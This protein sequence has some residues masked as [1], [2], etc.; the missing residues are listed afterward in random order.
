MD[1]Y[2]VSISQ[3]TTGGFMRITFLV[4]LLIIA[5]SSY[6]IEYLNLKTGI[7]DTASVD[8]CAHKI[9]L[10]EKKQQLYFQGVDYQ[11]KLCSDKALYVASGVAI[12]TYYWH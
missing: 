2:Y 9:V 4:S 10:D 3:H 7:Y 8:K 1:C 5:N 6:A 11:N 12:N